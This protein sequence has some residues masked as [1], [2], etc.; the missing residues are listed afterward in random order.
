M[1]WIIGHTCIA[2]LRAW[3]VTFLI[4]TIA[5]LGAPGWLPSSAVLFT[6]TGLLALPSRSPATRPRSATDAI[7]SLRKRCLTA[8][9][10][11]LATDWTTDVFRGPHHRSCVL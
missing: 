10:L 4:A 7:G 6:T 11:S 3:V 2:A 8:V 9:A 1:A 5:R